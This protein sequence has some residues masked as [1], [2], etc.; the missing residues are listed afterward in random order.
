M[1]RVIDV[2]P[3]FVLLL[4]APLCG[5][6]VTGSTPILMFLNPIAML[7]EIGLYGFGAILVRDLV[8]SRG[9]GWT[10]LLI[11][12]AAYGVLEE[13][14]VVTSWMNPH[15]PDAVSLGDRGRLLD[16]NWI[17]A[18]G[19]TAFHAVESIAVPI[20]LTE[21][22]FPSRAARAWLSDRGRRRVAVGLGVVCAIELL[23]FGFVQF[24]SQG[25][26]PPASWVVALAIAAALARYGL[27]H[28]FGAVVPW[29]VPSLWQLRAFALL[30]TFLFFGGLWALPSI[31]PIGIVPIAFIGVVLGFVAIRL[32]HWSAEAGW[33]DAQRLALATG[34]M[35]FFLGLA[36][37]LEF[38]MRPAGKN[39]SGMTLF[40]LAAVAFLAW[41]AR[42]TP[43][44]KAAQPLTTT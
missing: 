43:A 37:L 38:S 8:R 4:L 13:G 16:I 6:V 5:E 28:R 27:R 44:A 42:R 15:W 29:H 40:A 20:I 25:Y 21:A 3:T 2:A 34:V 17:W 14:L 11:L 18:V 9:L 7:F 31:V 26:S 23:F 19:L 32:R 35:S 39:T 12:G 36:P 24:R 22:L 10:S 1:P 30:A 41:L 33:G